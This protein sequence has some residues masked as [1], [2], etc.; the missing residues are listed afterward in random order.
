MESI[1]TPEQVETHLGS[2]EFPLGMPTEETA[3]R[4]YD[5]LDHVYAVSAFLNAYSG[6]DMWAFRKGFLDAGIRDHDVMICSE[7]MDAK[8]LVLTG[9]ADTVYFVTFLDLTEGP[10]VVEM[11]PGTLNFV[12]DMWF[13]WVTD[14][15]L[16]AMAMS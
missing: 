16:P 2:L 12:N 5:H 11:P 9:N 14:A 8:S 15:G 10:M 3:N 13:R 1:S 4:V 6:V 7:F